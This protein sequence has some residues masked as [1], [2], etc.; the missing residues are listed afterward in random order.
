M[1]DETRHLIDR[2]RDRLQAAARR[3]ST[4]DLAY[5]LLLTAGVVCALFVILVAIEARFWVPVSGRNF[6]FWLLVLCGTGLVI[7][8]VAR[9]LLRLVGLLPPSPD[10]EIA[11]QVSDRFPVLEDRLV[12]LLDLATGR[13]SAAPSAFVDEAVN[14]LHDRIQDV[15]LETATSFDPVRRVGR[16]ASIPAVGLLVFFIAA[17]G[18]FLGASARLLSPGVFFARPAPFVLSVTPGDA[19]LVRGETLHIQAFATGDDLPAILSL[20]LDQG[21]PVELSADEKGTFHYEIVNVRQS[22]EYRLYSRETATPW[23]SIEV[24]ERPVVRGLQVELIPPAYT[25]LPPQ[26]LPSGTGDILA[27]VGTE[28]RLDVRVDQAQAYIVHASGRVDTLSAGP[29]AQGAFRITLADSYHI[30]VE[31]EAGIRNQDPIEY[32][33]TPLRD[34]PPTIDIREP[35]PDAMLDMDLR[36]DLLVD[37]SDDFGFTDLTLWWRLVESRFDEVMESPSAIGLPLDAFPATDQTI[38]YA[39]DL[40]TTTGLDIVPGDALE[41]YVVVRDN[42]AVSGSKEAR[43]AIHRLRLPSVTERYDALSDQQLDTETEMASLLEESERLRD[44]FE[45]VRDELRQKQ[46]GDWDDRRQVEQLTE[47]Q[48][49]LEERVDALEAAMDETAGDM[50]DLVSPET[51]Q[52]FEELQQVMEEVNAPELMQAMEALQQAIDELNPAQMQEALE[53][54][55]FNEELFRERLERALELFKNFQVQQK[56][57]EAADRAEDLSEDQG[58]RADELGSDSNPSDEEREALADDQEASAEEMEALEAKMEEIA[59]RMEEVR[60]AP[61]EAMEQLNDQTAAQELPEQMQANA[62]QMREGQMQQAQQGQ[63]DMQQSLQ[64]LQQQLDNMLSGMQSSQEQ[65]SF[66]ALQRLLSDLL[67]LSHDQEALQR[68]IDGAAV[69]SPLL[70]EVAQEQSEMRALMGTAADSLQSLARMVPQMTRAVQARAGSALTSM[71]GAITAM[72][73]RNSGQAVRQQ[74]AAMTSLNELVLLLT[75]LM[76][77]LLNSQNNNSAGGMS[78]S[79]MIQQLQEMASDQRQL[80]RQIQEMLGQLQGQRLTPDMEARMQQMAMQQQAMRQQLEQLSRERALARQLAGDL[81]RIAEQMETTVQQLNAHSPDRELQTR[82]Q[83]ILTRLLD[84]S[85]AMQERGRQRQR[86]GQT[87]EQILRES[88]DGLSAAGAREQ[89]R[90]ALLDALESGYTPDYQELIRRY[91]EL[92]QQ[93]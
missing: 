67:Y 3:T 8:L 28:A 84:A 82:Q 25:G 85:R 89:L 48:K 62:Q 38:P 69:D 24:I 55:E 31:N 5:G 11:R 19:T 60:T 41:Y 30:L 20:Q 33:I 77:Q 16:L 83:Q 6:L 79:Q 74:H 63:Q 23:Y 75:E 70:R 73:A 49:A 72:V 35:E 26:Q 37:I 68:K 61:Q 91:F 43:S 54:V 80:N 32:S 7:A 87:G 22:L 15:P 76:A 64:Q 36:T 88:P 10:A 50:Q 39:W 56:L 9:P 18:S 66:N 71:D 78:M 4:R 58:Q 40:L 27:L 17:P 51:M 52:K 92:L 53:Q 13:A 42:D 81:D 34:L 59:R 47:A 14:N 2:L 90:R 93:Q 57:E 45:E 29:Q 1:S 12:N 86:E 65:I 46:Q 44:Q 21:E